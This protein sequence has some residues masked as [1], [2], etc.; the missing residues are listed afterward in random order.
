[1]AALVLENVVKIYPGNIR[2]VDDFTLEVAEGELVVLVGPSGCGK[3][4]TLRMVA[5][6]EPVTSGTIYIAGQAADGLSPKDRDVAMIFQN[7]ALYPH[8]TVAGNMAFGLKMRRIGKQEIQRRIY[9]TAEVL[10]IGDLLPR[11][12]AELSGGQ[13]QRVA[14]GRAIVRRPKIF[15][16]DEP[17]SNLD[18][19]LRDQMRREIRRIHTRLGA[20]TLYVTHD[21]TEAMT[22]GQRIAVIYQGRIQQV[23]DP[24]TLYRRPANCFVA[25]LIGSP[26][27][28]FFDGRIQRREQRL[29]FTTI[30][31]KDASDGDQSDGDQSDGDRAGFHG[32]GFPPN[33][34]PRVEVPV[35]A[36]WT[37]R[38]E[39]YLNQPIV[40][41]IRPEHIGSPAAEQMPCA[42]RISAK[43]EAIEPVGP[44]SYVY[45]NTGQHTFVSRVQTGHAPHIGD[46][47]QSSLV[48]DNLHFFDSHTA[49]AVEEK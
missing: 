10:G 5:G 34:P 30:T 36:E 14:L 35:P 13:Q 45:L 33:G 23:A 11:R 12:P 47:T 6:L 19:G 4:T 21:Q 44:E 27:M 40:L 32:P 39:P 20:A 49:K 7:Y 22:L 42:P 41:G 24:T 48:T 3:T 1:M 16:F 46:Y 25:A 8:M 38:I 18:A 28:N 9:Q 31:A 37:A 15:L 2:A 26:A 43:V 17:L 29:I